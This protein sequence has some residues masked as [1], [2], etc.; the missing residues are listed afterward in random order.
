MPVLTGALRSLGRWAG[1]LFLWTEHEQTFDSHQR[2]SSG[3]RHPPPGPRRF[4]AG[5]TESERRGAEEPGRGDA[6]VDRGGQEGLRRQLRQLPRQQGPGCR[7]SRRRH[8]DHPGAGRKAAARSDRR[9]MGPRLDRRRDLHR[10]QEGRAADDDGRLGR[11]ALGHRDLEHRQLPPRARG[12]QE[13]HCRAHRLPRTRHATPRPTL[14]LA[15][16]VQ[17]PI[18]GE[19]RRREHARPSWR[20]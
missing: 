6:R 16:Y 19:H 11:P 13:R 10:H 1:A 20:A 12:E 5:T 17:M 18:T 2:G 4:D 14:E 15:D 8:L 9:R 3:V 7:E